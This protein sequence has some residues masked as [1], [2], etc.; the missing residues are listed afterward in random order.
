MKTWNVRRIVAMAAI[1]VAPAA[2]AASPASAELS[3]T[4]AA[5]PAAATCRPGESCATKD[6][7]ELNNT[8]LSCWNNGGSPEV[9]ESGTGVHCHHADA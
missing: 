5:R 6:W 3:F 1:A 9:A 8:W 2:V 7:R 4:V